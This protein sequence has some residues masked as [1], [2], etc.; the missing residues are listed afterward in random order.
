MPR[1]SSRDASLGGSHVTGQP[2]SVCWSRSRRSRCASIWRVVEQLPPAAVGRR[3]EGERREAVALGV[4]V[5]VIPLRVRKLRGDGAGERLGA[6]AI[7]Y[8][9]EEAE[10]HREP[11]RVVRYLAVELAPA[12]V[13]G[14]V[15]PGM[16]DAERMEQP[17]DRRGRVQAGREVAVA[18]VVGARV[19]G[20]R[21]Q[22][23]RNAAVR[24]HAAR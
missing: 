17:R 8:V 7:R 2:P 6:L 4:G 10:R 23:A 20:D 12:E 18:P 19:G 9:L 24:P 5:G 11:V 13:G 21:G 14:R 22:H 3:G 16:I 15:E 1:H